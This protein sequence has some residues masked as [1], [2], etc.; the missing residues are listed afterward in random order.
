MSHATGLGLVD[1]AL[2]LAVDA[3][4]ASERYKK[5]SL[6]LKRLT[7]DT[8]ED[9][10]DACMAMTSLIQPWLAPLPL[11]DGNGNFGS[12][13]NDPP[14]DPG[15]TE[16]RLSPAGRAAV[17]AERGDGPP[18]PLGLVNGSTFRGGLR[19]PFSPAAVA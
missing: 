12:P 5:S 16:C 11:L 18:V 9:A 15:Y 1:T 6:I 2:L 8:G 7:A 19:P 10:S 4:G 14:A 17:A 3:A 13:G